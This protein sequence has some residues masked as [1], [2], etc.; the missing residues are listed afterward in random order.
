MQRLPTW[1]EVDL[2]NL[3]FNVTSIKRHIAAGTKILLVAKADAYGHG[4]VQIANALNDIVD[5]FGVATIDEATELRR[6]G[7]S[8]NKLLILSPILAKEIPRVIEEGFAVTVSYYELASQLSQ[9]A[10]AKGT[11]VEIHIETDTGMGRTGVPIEEAEEEISRMASL[12]GLQIGGVYT[13]FPVSDTDPDFTGGQINRFLELVAALRA[14]GVTIP[15]IHSANSSALDGIQASHM[16]MVRPGLLA[17]GHLA[18]GVESAIPARPVMSWKSR[19]VQIR[20]IPGGRPISY[21]K[22][23]ITRRDTILGVVPVGYG[24]GLPFKISNRGEMLI[25][26]SR[27]PI[28]GR[29]TMDMTMVDLTD[30]KPTPVPGDEVVF[31]GT[32]NGNSISLHELSAWAE[33]IPY[34]IL[35]GIS[36]RVPRTY[37]RKGKVESYKSLLGVIADHICTS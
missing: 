31:F 20:T 34:E 13:H 36:K 16:D 8:Q 10:E 24:H 22:T 29:V 7:I 35:C 18:N 28:L 15:I 2:D 25:G 21:G 37:L 26:G 19:L 4:S 23:C 32:Q 12:P 9:H 5:M 30:L 11:K 27:V 1:V 3:L 17:F 14:K 33:T 6:S